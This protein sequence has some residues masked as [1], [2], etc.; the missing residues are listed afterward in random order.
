MCGLN[1]KAG[2]NFTWGK[3]LVVGFLLWTKL[4]LA[5]AV[6]FVATAVFCMRALLQKLVAG[7]IAT[8]AKGLRALRVGFLLA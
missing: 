8:L 7:F 3:K 1:V 5:F 4:A 6:I 2:V